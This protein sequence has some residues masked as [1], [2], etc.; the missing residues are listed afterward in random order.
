MLNVNEIFSKSEHRYEKSVEES[1]W[2][3]KSGYK[4]Q[5]E[6]NVYPHRALPNSF[7]GLNVVLSL[8]T[9]DL[10]FMCKGPV[11]G[12]KVKIHSSN[13][14][15]QISEGYFRIPLN[16]EV[17]VGLKPEKISDE[18]KFDGTCHTYESKTL[19]YFKKYSQS[20]C[21]DECR[22]D[23]VH[24]NCGCIK[25]N[26][27]HDNK[28]KVCTQHDTQCIVDAVDKFSTIE[29][30]KS[31]FPCDC[32]PSCSYLKYET[33]ITT[34]VFNF[35]QVF[36]AYDQSMDGEFPQAMMSRLSI[37]FKED[38]YTSRTLTNVKQSW[39]E[40]ASQIGGILALFMG[41]SIMSFVEIFYWFICRLFK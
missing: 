1:M 29:R 40:F 27:P 19:K 23:Y 13:E 33:D 21:L 31:D 32:R 8:K 4:D 28:T 3:L 12:F 25:F 34:A 30:F 7:Y 11:Q 37:Y 36:D 18:T 14:F 39:S 35:K 22:S 15:P 2:D 20:N 9:S 16:E 26:M 24:K 38:H 17:I 5:K 10:D 6:F 41:A